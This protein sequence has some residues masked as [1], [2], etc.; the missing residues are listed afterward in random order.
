MTQDEIDAAATHLATRA[1]REI[2]VR[3]IETLYPHHLDALNIHETILTAQLTL[4]WLNPKTITRAKAL[5]VVTS[6]FLIPVLA[7]MWLTWRI[8][9]LAGSRHGKHRPTPTS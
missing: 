8:A 6:P 7:I 3:T 9:I 2:D 4:T 5:A 1:L